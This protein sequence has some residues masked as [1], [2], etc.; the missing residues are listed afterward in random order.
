M[1]LVDEIRS[2]LFEFCRLWS[3]RV[4][5]FCSLLCIGVFETEERQRHN[6]V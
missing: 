4:G 6:G 2:G 1:L 5:V 3:M